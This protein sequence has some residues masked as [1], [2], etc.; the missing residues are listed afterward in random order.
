[1]VG[2]RWKKASEDQKNWL[3]AIGMAKSGFG[4]GLKS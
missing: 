1:M 4:A 2:K 3:L